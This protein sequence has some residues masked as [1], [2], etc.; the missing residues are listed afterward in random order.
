MCIRLQVGVAG[1][2][3]FAGVVGSKGSR[4]SIRITRITRA[5]GF[6]GGSE[7]SSSTRVFTCYSTCAEALAVTATW[8]AM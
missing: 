3:E 4:G 5:I 1:S 8:G 6:S 2:V 7:G